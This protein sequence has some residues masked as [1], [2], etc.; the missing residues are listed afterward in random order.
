A[1]GKSRP[2]TTTQPRFLDLLDELLRAE[3][4]EHPGQRRVAAALA[5]RLDAGDA[6]ELYIFRDDARVGAEGQRLHLRL[7]RDRA[8]RLRHIIAPSRASAAARSHH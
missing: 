3:L 5:I 4:L 1:G 6:G 8:C 2:T 7:R